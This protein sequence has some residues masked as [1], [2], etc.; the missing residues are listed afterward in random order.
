MAPPI[1]LDILRHNDHL[2]RV[3][4]QL[5]R[6]SKTDEEVHAICLQQTCNAW[7][8]MHGRGCA[9]GTAQDATCL[10]PLPN[11]AQGQLNLAESSD[12][13]DEEEEEEEDEDEHTAH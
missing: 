5:C 6:P 3:V 8:G 1:T 7:K 13:E 12:K 10:S 2:K 9:C 11:E 4:P